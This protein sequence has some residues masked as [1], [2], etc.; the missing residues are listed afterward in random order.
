MKALVNTVIVLRNV[1]PVL[2]FY[3][4]YFYCQYAEMELVERFLIHM[5]DQDGT[6]QFCICSHS[7][8]ASK[9][10]NKIYVTFPLHSTYYL[11]RWG[12]T[13]PHQFWLVVQL[14][15]DLWDSLAVQFCNDM[16]HHSNQSPM[17]HDPLRYLLLFTTLHLIVS[18]WIAFL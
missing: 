5:H 17:I 14:T 6:H 11:I 18:Y 13:S 8:H 7:C 2:G 4:Q 1:Y 3:I 10:G 9:K 16:L 15:M 12:M